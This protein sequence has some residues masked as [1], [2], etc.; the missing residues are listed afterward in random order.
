MIYVTSDIHGCFN[1]FKKLLEYVQFSEKDKLYI[2]G[3]VLGRGDEPIPLLRYVMAHENMELLLGNHEQAFLWNLDKNTSPMSDEDIRVLWLKHSGPQTFEQ[4]Q[5]LTEGEK[6]RVLDYVKA[7]PM[8][9]VI[10]KN[11]LV[12]AGIEIKKE[13]ADLPE[14]VDEK[15]LKELMKDQKSF[16]IL[17]QTKDFYCESLDFK[18]P[19]IRV[20]FGHMFSLIIRQDRGEPLDS[21]EIWKDKNRIGLDCGYAFGGKMVMYCLD[22]DEVHYLTSSGEL[23]T[24]S[25]I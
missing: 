14:N 12:H 16:K 17:W 22:T 21:T 2:V 3:D 20:F 7:C 19:D 11:I 15:I 25:C 9:K 10:G 18:D 6:R 8:Y 5:A 23:Y 1:E 13:Y 4:Y 24:K